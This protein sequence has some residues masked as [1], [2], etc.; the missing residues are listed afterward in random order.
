[1]TAYRKAERTDEPTALPDPESQ[2]QDSLVVGDVF[3]VLAN[4]NFVFE[5][6]ALV[7]DRGDQ[8]CGPACQKNRADIRPTVHQCEVSADRRHIASGE[9]TAEER[10]LLQPGR[11]GGTG[12]NRL[13]GC[14]RTDDKFIP[15]FFNLVQSKLGKIDRHLRLDSGFQAVD[16][17][18]SSIEH[19]LIV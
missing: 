14:H 6:L 13:Q 7:T 18:P 16:L 10:R 9:R 15:F 3:M 5:V 17:R 8:E 2:N 12:C 11:N 19:T 4:R 1:M